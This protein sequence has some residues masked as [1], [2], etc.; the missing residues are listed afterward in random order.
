MEGEGT[1]SLTQE[2]V[3]LFRSLGLRAT[4]EVREDGTAILD[5]FG[6]QEDVTCD[7]ESGTL[8]MYGAEYPFTVEG[9]TLRIDQGTSAFVFERTE[10]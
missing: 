3:E 10:D 5:L 2:D 9:D 7:A 8:T 1:N 6:E 4:I